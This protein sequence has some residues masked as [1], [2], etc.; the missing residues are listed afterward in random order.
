MR[1]LDDA[2]SLRV[3]VN[4]PC[5]LLPG[6]DRTAATTIQKFRWGL[7]QPTRDGL[8]AGRSAWTG[9]AGRQ[10]QVV[11]TDDSVIFLNGVRYRG[12]LTILRNNAG[13]LQVNND[14]P[15]E[16]YLKGVVSREVDA[17]WPMAALEA[18]AIVARTFTIRQVQDRA[19]QAFDVT[20]RWPQLYGGLQDERPRATQAVE[21]TRGLVVTAGGRLV[22]TYYHTVCG[23]RTEDA[24]AVWPSV[25]SPA[26]RSVECIYCRRAPH[27]RWSLAVS[28]EEL[29]QA[30]AGGGV[31]VGPLTDLQLGPRNRS[32]RVT[33]VTVIGLGGA[34][35]VSAV[36][37]RA[38]LG[39]NRLRSANC[40]VQPSGNDR[41]IFE[42]FGWGHGVGLCQW[43]ASGLAQR[44]QTAQQILQFYYPGT[45][46]T[47]W[48][49]S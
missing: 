38:E 44:R 34:A 35:T 29:A 39:S 7:I 25:K 16:Q 15:L 4:G 13:S 1:V 19:G 30:L 45:E 41:W 26:L 14:V 48:P 20:M 27:Y 6:G 40:T 17:R 8:Q 23:G 47:T 3:T 31:D 46:I 37:L 12:A 22:L 28:S 21:R 10:L 43:G 42:G 9:R 36:Q 32:G 2:P 24:E 5:R 33:T 18:Q 49:A 11:P